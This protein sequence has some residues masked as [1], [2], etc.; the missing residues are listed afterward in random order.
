MT[1]KQFLALEDYHTKLDQK[2]ENK[3]NWL[4]TKTLITAQ[5]NSELFGKKLTAQWSEFSNTTLTYYS[6]FNIARVTV[7]VYLF[8]FFLTDPTAIY[9]YNM[10]W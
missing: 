6:A 4:P 8:F 9:I 1:L 7:T 5:Q 3:S 10:F 2:S